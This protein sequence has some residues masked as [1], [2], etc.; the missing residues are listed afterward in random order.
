MPTLLNNRYLVLIKENQDFRYL[1]F[2]QIVSLLGDW[3]NLIASATLVANLSNSGLAI[4]GIFLA[5]F[6]PPFLLGPVV[7]V[8]AD[9]F[10]R[11][12]ILILSDVLRT[13]IVLNF[14][15]IQDVQDIWLLYV[16]TILQL[17]ISAFFEPARA[18][19]L[20]TIVARQDIITANA[21]AGA[22]WSV[23]LAL[24]AALGGLITA[25]L[26]TTSAFIIDAATFLLVS[27]WFVLQMPSWTK[28]THK[29]PQV[30]GSAGWQ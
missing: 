23:M 26:G 4:G 16:L 10:D 30:A 5:R 25:L 15:F 22:T 11:R 7:G 19:I 17:S 3:F 18:A 29:K 21:L 6:L 13:V 1:W 8:V 28:L 24:G 9:R 27:A 12:K 2:S 14:L 20:P